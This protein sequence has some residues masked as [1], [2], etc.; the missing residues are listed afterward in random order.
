M[1]R[2]KF[3]ALSLFTFL[4]AGC[5]PL[6]IFGAGTAAGVAGYKYYQGALTVVFQAPF[7]KTWDGTLTALGEMQLEIES[8]DHDLTSGIIRAKRSDKKEVKVSLAYKSAK[9]TEVVIRVGLFGDKEA[10]LAIK[11]RI[12]QVLNRN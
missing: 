10:S 9:E 6:I 8:S 7:M 4:M 1:I 5:A 11:D 12:A 2:F 3:A